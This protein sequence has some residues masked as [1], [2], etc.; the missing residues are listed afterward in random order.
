VT[1]ITELQPKTRLQGVVRETQLYGA[2]VDIGLEQDGLV[3]ISQLAPT[4]VN[5]VSDVVKPG[6]SVT[7]W[8]TKVDP[9]KGRVGLTMV[10]PPRVD[11]RELQEGQTRTGTVTRLESYGA[12]VDIGAERPGLLHVRE[13]SS[14]YVR[15]PSEIVQVSEEVEVRILK[16][17]Q[18]K[19]RI[20]LT[21]TGVEAEAE[22]AT[23]PEEEPAKTAMEIALHHAGQQHAQRQRREKR[24]PPELAERGDILTRTLEQHARR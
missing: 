23:A 10:E 8:V 11:W 5:R 14:G 24:Q 15:H 19:R 4:R 20:D 9:E 6:D 7:V 16:L 18:Q 13:M 2:I 22:A 3:H 12:F 17:D 1:S 21:M